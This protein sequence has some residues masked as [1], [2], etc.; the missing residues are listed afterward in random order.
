MQE[1]LSTD[2]IDSITYKFIFATGL[3]MGVTAELLV[4]L[5]G[6]KRKDKV[7]SKILFCV[8][9]YQKLGRT[10]GRDLCFFKKGLLTVI[11]CLFQR[12][13]VFKLYN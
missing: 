1:G 12:I 6:N 4:G 11:F 8:L 13:K 9:R 7:R 2:T 10:D 5:R 3:D